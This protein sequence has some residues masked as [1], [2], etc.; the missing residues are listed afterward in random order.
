MVGSTKLLSPGTGSWGGAG[1]LAAVTGSSID[2]IGGC[3]L[4]LEGLRYWVA[5]AAYADGMLLPPPG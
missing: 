5:V 4:W 2:G 1:T 3:V